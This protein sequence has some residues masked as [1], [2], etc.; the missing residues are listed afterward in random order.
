MHRTAARAA[1]SSIPLEIGQ[2]KDGGF[3]WILT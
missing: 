3:L 1:H 2:G